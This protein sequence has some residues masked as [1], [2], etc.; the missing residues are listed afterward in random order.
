M[1]VEIFLPDLLNEEELRHETGLHLRQFF[2]FRNRFVPTPDRTVKLCR[3]AI[4]YSSL[5]KLRKDPSYRS[6][7]SN[8]SVAGS[9]LQRH[10]WKVIANVQ[11]TDNSLPQRWAFQ[12][13]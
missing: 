10:E 7:R 13:P 12:N 11:N 4:A 9:T 1:L 6:Q 3:D 8:T 5:S 2:D